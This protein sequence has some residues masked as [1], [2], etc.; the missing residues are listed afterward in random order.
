MSNAFGCPGCLFISVPGNQGGNG[1]RKK[2]KKGHCVQLGI[3]L[4]NLG[5]ELLTE[6]LY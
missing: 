2:M 4:A 5:H 3:I 6:Y 1:K